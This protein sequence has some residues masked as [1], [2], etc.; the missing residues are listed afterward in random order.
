MSTDSNL[1]G[2]LPIA[3]SPQR[4]SGMKILEH[5]K[6]PTEP[7]YS[8]PASSDSWRQTGFNLGTDLRLIQSGLDIS[9][10]AVS[11][12]YRPQSRSM[13]MAGY[14]SQWSR[15]LLSAADA[16]LLI[17]SGSYQSAMSVIRQ[18]VESA[19]AFRGLEQEMQ[20]WTRWTHEAFSTHANTRAIEI[21]MGI[22]FAGS[23]IASEE[24][25]RNIYRAA[26]DFGRPNFGPTSLFVANEATHEKYPLHFG[27]KSFHIGWSQLLLGW[28]NTILDFLLETASQNPNEFPI[29]D[30][31]QSKISLYKEEVHR[32]LSDPNR[33]NLDEFTDAEGRKRHL[34]TNFRRQPSD[35]P[36]RII[37]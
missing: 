26:S 30:A 18:S 24:S 33:C 1:F 15:S 2:E 19:A 11:S 36:S 21:G 13:V 22:Y 27:D 8:D 16:V 31:T 4:V 34:L 25:I 37:F 28:T 7:V 32:L 29:E 10:E 20:E 3:D 14:A 35:A 9:L 6:L 17:R 12:G 23:V 5:L